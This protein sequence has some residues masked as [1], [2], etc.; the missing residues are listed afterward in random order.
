M[1]TLVFLKNV[2]L[3]QKIVL[4]KSFIAITFQPFRSKNEHFNQKTEN[5]DLIC[6][7]FLMKKLYSYELIRESNSLFVIICCYIFVK[8]RNSN[9]EKNI[10]SIKSFVANGVC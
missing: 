9:Y 1:D 6:I 3:N 4:L 2:K 5:I 8:T 10:L 7:V